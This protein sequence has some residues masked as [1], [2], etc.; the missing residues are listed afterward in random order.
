MTNFKKKSGSPRCYETDIP[1]YLQNELSRE[2]KLAFENHIAICASC[3][4]ETEQYRRLIGLLLQPL[5]AIPKRD[6][7]PDILLKVQADGRSDFGGRTRAIASSPAFLR[8]AALFLCLVT[9]GVLFSV[10]HPRARS[11]AGPKYDQ[12]VD[13]AIEWL[14]SAQEPDGHWDSSKWGAQKY[15]TPGITALAILAVL[16]QDPN[17]MGE[18]FAETIRRGLDYLLSLQNG[19][20]RIGPLNSGTPYN[21]GIATLAMLEACDRQKN[22]GCKPAVERSLKYIQKTQLAAG[23]WGYPRVPD[24]SGNTSITVW[25]LLALLKAEAMG[26][27]DVRPSIEKGMTWLDR[28]VDPDGTIGYNRP[29]NFP[30]G[31]ET[32]TA[33]GALCFLTDKGR[34][35]P[36]PHL[37]Q[38]M[39]TLRNAA[40]QKADVDYYRLYFI[41][42]ALQ[43]AGGEDPE[44]ITGLREA[45]VAC[46]TQNGV[47]AGSFEASDRWGSAGGRVYAT[48]MAVLA[49]K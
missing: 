39:K 30:Y 32:L 42:R 3:A 1:A 34:S 44:L 35:V 20:G 47:L 25:Q 40:R 6:L 5:P 7:A 38:V 37:V 48:A 45:L 17:A 21:Q 2:Q 22:T 12:R 10:L 49:L 15:F 41:T 4:A 19:E 23:G 29:L 8:A 9:A 26:R 46:Q 18:Q 33:A 14:C 43:A 28:V 11:V 13:A 16:K 31:H 27:T 36:T 24:D